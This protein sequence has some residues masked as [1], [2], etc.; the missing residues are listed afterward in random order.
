MCATYSAHLILLDLITLI[1]IDVGYEL[2]KS[3]CRFL[4]FHPSLVQIFS[5]APSSIRKDLETEGPDFWQYG[6]NEEENPKWQW[7]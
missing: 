5:S 7:N 1:I 6:M 3:S 2:G 4:L